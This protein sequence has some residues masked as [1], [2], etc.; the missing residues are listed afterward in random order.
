MPSG[1]ECIASSASVLVNRRASATVPA[2]PRQGVQSSP[3]LAVVRGEPSA[4]ELAAVIVALAGRAGQV[5]AERRPQRSQWSARAR[6]MR[7]PLR[8]GPGAWRASALP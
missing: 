2:D 5:R 3:V 6:L 8:P 4:E 1:L 7:P